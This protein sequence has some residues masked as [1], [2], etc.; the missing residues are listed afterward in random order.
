MNTSLFWKYV[1]MCIYLHIYTYTYINDFCFVFYQKLKSF[2]NWHCSFSRKYKMWSAN[3]TS[4]FTCTVA[5]SHS[6]IRLNQHILIPA[7]NDYRVTSE[8]NLQCECWLIFEVSFGFITVSMSVN[9]WKVVVEKQKFGE[10]NH[11]KNMIV[12]DNLFITC[13]FLIVASSKCNSLSL[14]LVYV[15]SVIPILYCS[16][17]HCMFVSDTMHI[18]YT[19]LFSH[20]N[21]PNLIKQHFYL[22]A[23]LIARFD[24]FSHVKTCSSQTHWKRQQQ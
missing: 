9:C 13:C 23:D 5:G 18:T 6:P 8:Q 22:T 10:M 3:V 17:W 7:A 20:A 2:V 4:Y 1:C 19:G 16:Y 14:V 24:T 21:G 15:V 12:V 11:T